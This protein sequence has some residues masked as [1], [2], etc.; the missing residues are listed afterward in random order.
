[1]SWKS[2]LAQ[3]FIGLLGP[4]DLQEIAG[5]AIVQITSK[6]KSEERLAFFQRFVEEHLS[7][8]LAGLGRD[9]RARLMNALLPRLAQEFP[10][11]DLD[12]LGAFSSA[13]GK[14]WGKEE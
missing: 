12:I 8:L 9:E 13:E 3:A 10:L 2:R 5:R 11:A 4:R 6:L 7:S 14:P 1:M